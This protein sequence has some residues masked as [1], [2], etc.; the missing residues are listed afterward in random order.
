M[1]SISQEHIVDKI[2]QNLGR[3]EGKPQVFK[4]WKYKTFWGGIRFKI[5]YNPSFELK[6]SK[7]IIEPTLYWSF[8]EAVQKEL[9]KMK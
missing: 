7:F 9:E 3:C 6:P 8:Q 4:I 5:T 1:S 2:I